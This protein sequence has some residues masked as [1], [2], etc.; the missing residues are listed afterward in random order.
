MVVL[1]E[2]AAVTSGRNSTVSQPR[3]VIALGVT[4]VLDVPLD[5]PIPRD[6]ERIRRVPATTKARLLRMRPV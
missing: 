3:D 4:T 6:I 1:A 2:A 5:A